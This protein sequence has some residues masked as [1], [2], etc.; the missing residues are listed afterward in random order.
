MKTVKSSLLEARKILKESGA[1]EYALD[2]ELF[3]MKAAGL[4]RVQLFTKDEY[5]LSEEEEKAFWG[6]VEKRRQGMPAQY[7][8]G[9]CN[10][11]DLDFF[12]N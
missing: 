2:A 1:G 3:M 12:V 6:M 10:F 9:K 4:T 11:M 7:I 5:I 8:T